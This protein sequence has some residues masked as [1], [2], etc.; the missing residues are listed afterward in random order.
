[1]HEEAVGGG[2]SRSSPREV[3]L[4]VGQLLRGSPLLQSHLNYGTNALPGQ[5]T[6]G[7]DRQT[8][9]SHVGP[10][11]APGSAPG[12]VAAP[13][14]LPPSSASS[15]GRPYLLAVSSGGTTISTSRSTLV[16][17]SGDPNPNCDTTS[18]PSSRNKE[19]DGIT[20]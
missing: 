1:M 20:A 3:L 13:P 2:V 19:C 10:L 9:T 5:P 7:D 14:A 15:S 8:E 11:Q 17:A 12:V 16:S 18:C 6:L 4:L